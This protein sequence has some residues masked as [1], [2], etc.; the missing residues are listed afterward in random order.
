MR[1]GA[2]SPGRSTLSLRRLGVD[3][4]DAVQRVA[5]DYPYGEMALQQR[6]RDLAGG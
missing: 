2:T 4:L 6:D 1:L 3:I 5:T